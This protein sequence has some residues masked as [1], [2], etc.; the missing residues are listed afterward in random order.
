MRQPQN[1]FR[2]PYPGAIKAIGL[3]TESG[4]PVRVS[5]GKGAE[6]D[7]H[8]TM[9]PYFGLK[10]ESAANQSNELREFGPLFLA[11]VLQVINREVQI[12]PCDFS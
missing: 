7:H 8:L 4:Y 2:Y 10:L 12:H 6:H 11:V 1:I 3:T 5:L 9:H